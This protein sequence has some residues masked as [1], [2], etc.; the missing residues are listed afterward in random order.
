[1]ESPMCKKCGEV[2][3]PRDEII[4]NLGGSMPEWRTKLYNC[5]SG[6]AHL[7]AFIGE[8]CDVMACEDVTVEIELVKDGQ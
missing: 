7:V 6:H 5:P 1:M 4:V 3:K 8:K 2:L